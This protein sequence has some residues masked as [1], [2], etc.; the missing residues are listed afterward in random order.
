MLFHRPRASI[1]RLMNPSCKCD[2]PKTTLWHTETLE[3]EMPHKERK[4]QRSIGRGRNLGNQTVHLS[5][6]RIPDPLSAMVILICSDGHNHMSSTHISLEERPTVPSA[7]GGSS[8][9]PSPHPAGLISA[10]EL[11]SKVSS[12]P[13]KPTASGYCGNIN[14]R[15]THF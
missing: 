5:P 13:W 4:R 10:A 9:A 2:D 8:I 7:G 6:S 12:F 11:R 14:L 15:S 3:D 1:S